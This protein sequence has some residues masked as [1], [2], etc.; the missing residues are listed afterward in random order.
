MWNLSQNG[1]YTLLLSR[2]LPGNQFLSND[3]ASAYLLRSCRTRH[4]TWPVPP[5][6]GRT[7]D[8]LLETLDFLVRL[9]CVVFVRASFGFCM[10]AEGA[11][12]VQTA[13]QIIALFL[14][15]RG[16]CGPLSY[17][18]LSLFLVRFTVL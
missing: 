16:G 4:P 7:E 1:Y 6:N 17:V 15:L 14:A 2:A 9:F 8:F 5:S 13:F 10:L 12:S 11:A 3:D 18:L